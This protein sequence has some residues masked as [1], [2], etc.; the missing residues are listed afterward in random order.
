M[1]RLAILS[2]VH[3]NLG[4]LTAVL[5]AIDAAKPDHVAIAGDHVFNGP[6]PAG[7]VDALL[8]AR[9]DARAARDWGTADAIRDALDGLGLKVEDTPQG[10][11]VVSTE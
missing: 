8:A 3:G 5:H 2:D 11:R 1:P 4:A 9:A 7:A 6:D 10:A